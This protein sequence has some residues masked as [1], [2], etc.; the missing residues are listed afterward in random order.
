MYKSSP[1]LWVAIASNQLEFIWTFSDLIAKRVA[2]WTNLAEIKKKLLPLLYG[3]IKN[4]LLKR[5]FR[6]TRM[7]A[8]VSQSPENLQSPLARAVITVPALH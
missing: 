5:V 2:G 1:G 3:L 8:I 7:C 4:K 6:H